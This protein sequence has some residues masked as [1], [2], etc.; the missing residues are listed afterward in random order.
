MKAAAELTPFLPSD[1]FTGGRDGYVFKRGAKGL[2]YYMDVDLVTG[3]LR[4]SSANV[5]REL[6]RQ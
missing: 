2:G 4:S 5:A 1:R 3:E 6:F